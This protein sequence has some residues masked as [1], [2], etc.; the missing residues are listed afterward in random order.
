MKTL[1]VIAVALVTMLVSGCATETGQA[2]R[3]KA[4]ENAAAEADASLENGI[5]LV[6]PAATTGAVTRR[7]GA[8]PGAMQA[9]ADFCQYQTMP[10][11]K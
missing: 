7:W 6:C 2:F 3:T 4:A 8:D 10:V 5:W 11:G 1:F 9:W